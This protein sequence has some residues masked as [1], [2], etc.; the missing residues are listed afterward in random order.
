MGTLWTTTGGVTLQENPYSWA[1]FATL[2]FL[3]SPV[4]VGFSWAESADAL[5][6]DDDS[7]AADNL[8]SVI[9]WR[10]RFPVHAA[11]PMWIAG[12]SYAGVY[13]PMLSA[14]IVAYNAAVPPAATPVP[15]SPGKRHRA[16]RPSPSPLI[17][18]KGIL[19]GNGC[20]GNEVG[21]CSL[22]RANANARSSYTSLTTYF[23]HGVLSPPLYL[24]VIQ[25]CGPDFL[26]PVSPTP[27]ACADAIDAAFE[28]ISSQVNIYHLYDD[29]FGICDYSA[30]LLNSLA[31]ARVPVDANSPTGRL[32]RRASST[33]SR[34]LGG[35]SNSTAAAP[36]RAGLVSSPTCTNPDDISTY[37]SSP[38]VQTALNVQSR[39]LARWSVCWGIPYTKTMADERV[40][41]YPSLVEAGLSITIYAGDVDGCVPSL[42][43][44]WWTSS[45]GYP[46]VEGTSAWQ[47]W[48]ASD[49][50]LGGY[51]TRFAPP[52][53]PAGGSF[54][55]LTVRGAGHMDRTRA[56]NGG[57]RAVPPLVTSARL[58]S[59]ALG[60]LPS[61]AGPANEPSLRLR[62]CV[63]H[64]GREQVRRRAYAVAVGPTA[65]GTWH[66]SSINGRPAGRARFWGLGNGRRA[67]LAWSS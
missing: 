45:M 5:A 66:G 37:L 65:W 34:N 30:N 24:A 13:I 12:E 48:T 29:S 38:R 19:I 1:R 20:V 14:A 67:V 39:P 54:T 17:P 50:S 52:D 10:A 31:N 25:A 28:S 59:H 11:N 62:L 55:F 41:V 8:A 42:D 51:V 40:A 16:S 43:N 15:R 46:L 22:Y 53:A 32:M 27:P 60:A 47:A 26:T 9:A 33:S 6:V 49:G 2:V 3:E 56:G 57:C 44:F 21:V 7:T 61:P 23:G 18:L 58:G 36:R 63:V 64:C 4:G 35:G